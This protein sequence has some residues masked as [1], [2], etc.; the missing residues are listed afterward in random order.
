[1]TLRKEEPVKMILDSYEIPENQ[2]IWSMIGL[3]YSVAEGAFLQKKK[4][5]VRW[6]E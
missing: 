6:V 3:G 2:V 5:V 4:D 1:M